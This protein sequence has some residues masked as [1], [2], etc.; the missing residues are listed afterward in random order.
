MKLTTAAFFLLMVIT[1]SYSSC[2]KNDVKTDNDDDVT[3]ELSSQ[4]AISDN[5]E[6]DAQDLLI[7]T[8][9]ENNFSGNTKVTF[10]GAEDIAGCATVTVSPLEGFP[11]M[12]TVDF[13]DGCTSING[14]TRKGVIHLVVSNFLRNTGSTSV[15]T[16]D[17]YS[18]NGFKKEGTITWTNKSF[19]TVKIW[20]RKSEAVN[21]TAP[22]GKNWQHSG[23]KTITQE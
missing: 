11:K 10:N 21:V 3:F 23:I 4:Q 8:S 12:I 19:A 14:V 7:Q 16:F 18:V 13:G 20:E 22:S 1:L 5:L 15:M 17:N 9:V 2:K 6:E